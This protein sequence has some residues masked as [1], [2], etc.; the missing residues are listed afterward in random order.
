MHPSSVF[1]PDPLTWVVPAGQSKKVE[2]EFN[3][4]GPRNDDE[5]LIMQVKDGA[6]EEV[7]C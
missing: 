7:K 6:D 1:I 2:I 4:A 3:P 5:T